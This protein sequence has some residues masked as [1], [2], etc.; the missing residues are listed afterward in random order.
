MG[1]GG[2]WQ[3]GEGTSQRTSQRPLERLSR[4]SAWK[5]STEFH[6]TPTKTLPCPA[7]ESVTL[8]AH[9]ARWFPEGAAQGSV[10][11]N[12]T[13]TRFPRRHPVRVQL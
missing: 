7:L 11:G 3:E 6:R 13:R 10:C 5:H 12:L 8:Q 4:T 9:E 2:S 1:I